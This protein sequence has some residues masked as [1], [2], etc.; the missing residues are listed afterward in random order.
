MG[1]PENVAEDI[2]L[3]EGR[4]ETDTDTDLEAHIG[5]RVFVDLRPKERDADGTE[6]RLDIDD[7]D[8]LSD[9]RRIFELEQHGTKLTGVLREVD[10]LDLSGEVV[11][12]AC[13][14]GI[15]QS[16][17]HIIHP[18]PMFDESD[19]EHGSMVVGEQGFC[20]VET[21]DGIARFVEAADVTPLESDEDDS[22]CPGDLIENEANPSGLEKNRRSLEE[23]Y[24]NDHE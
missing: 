4:P 24:W 21:D 6:R 3:D 10:V 9:T 2:E 22:I 12:D 11:Y 23:R 5:E 13:L 20:L 15:S 8:L 7:L 17:T 1:L 14:D 19:G 18:N 16:P